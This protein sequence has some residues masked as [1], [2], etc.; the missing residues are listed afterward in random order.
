MILAGIQTSIELND[1]FSMVLNNIIAS[2]SSATA[3]IGDLQGSMNA[4]VATDSLYA[5]NEQL[6]QA[7]A[8]A[9]QLSN[10]LTEVK[11]P[12]QESVRKQEELNRKIKE[13]ENR[14][15]KLTRK[16]RGM[17]GAYLGIQSVKEVLSTSD[18]LTSTTARLNMMNDGRQ[19]TDELFNMVYAAAQ[20]SRGSLP[21]MANVVARFGNNAGDAFD[22]SEEVVAFADLVQK[23][24]KIAGASSQEASN[25]I[26]QLSQALGSGVLRGDEL[27]SIFEQ[28][29]NLIQNIADYLDVPIGKIREMASDGKLTADIVKAAIF[30]NAGEINAAFE[31]MPMTWVD[32]WTS[33]QNTAL[34]AFRPVLRQ[35]N[36]IANSDDFQTFTVNATHALA[37]LGSMA[38]NVLDL[39]IQ[40]ANFVSDNWSVIG[41]IVYGVVAALAVYAAHLGIVKG[42]E[43]A[44][45]AAKGALALAQF[46]Q[47]AALAAVTGATISAQAAQMGLNGAMYACPIV[48]IIVLIVAL[49]AAFYAAVGAV[50]RFAGTSISATGL[51]TGAFAVLGAYLINQFVVPVFNAFAALSNFVGNVFN[52]PVAAIK[53]LFYDMCLTILG[54]FRTL[55]NGIESVLNKIPGVTVDIT[56]GL[57]A[58]YSGL[59]QAQQAVKD[60]SGWVEYV[61]K[62]EYLDYSKAAS[63]GYNFGENLSFEKLFGAVDIP[64]PTSYTSGFEDAIANS[65]VGSNLEGINDST[66]G[67]KDSLDITEED[68]KYL[69]DLAEQ[70]TVNRYTLAEVHIDQSGMQN[71][72]NNGDDVD[73]FVTKLTDS[74]A[75]AVDIMTEGVHD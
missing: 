72:I 6:V 29:P 40:G 61:G 58:F 16:L 75:E 13:G 74:M 52:N 48:W 47:V 31:D 19:S 56:S 43:L 36:R 10:S 59:E 54:Y 41:P 64:D 23:Q 32:I 73:G 5:A 14:T 17:V 53:V 20:D 33:F 51:I 44:S 34:I 37:I 21:D 67:I 50:N 25:A 35:L 66:K 30:D 38:V 46:A 42:M 71:H 8:N 1:Q 22:S 15:E 11:D 7:A 70:E 69:R 68:L 62:M 24:M 45:V 18:E 2:V 12:I 49:I 57:D 27:N 63:A 26:L 4:N 65:G 55:A 39:L 9:V 3:A 28:A 60:E